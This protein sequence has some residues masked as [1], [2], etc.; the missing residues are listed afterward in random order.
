MMRQANSIT[1]V[2]LKSLALVILAILAGA[3][4]LR[5]ARATTAH[6]VEESC[7]T[8]VEQFYNY[9]EPLEPGHTLEST[10]LGDAV[11][12]KQFDPLL[13]QQLRVVLDTQAKSGQIRLEFDP[14]INGRE[15]ADKYEASNVTRKGEHYLVEVYGVSGDGRKHDNP[16]VIA[17]VEPQ[18][19]EWM[20]VNFHYPNR[21]DSA[22]NEN[23]L[24]MLKQILKSQLE[25]NHVQPGSVPDGAPR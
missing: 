19:G 25:E 21:A 12:K 2:V 4:G 18:G 13:A 14:I 5:R 1:A 15:P 17:E 6:D 7:R 22:E 8:F 20:F 23:L 10:S 16:D 24:S 3:F 9:Y 11:E